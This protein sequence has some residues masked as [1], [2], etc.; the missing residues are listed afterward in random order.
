M[1]F[2]PGRPS[3]A[4]TYPGVRLVQADPEPADALP[5]HMRIPA[6]IAACRPIQD[7]LNSPAN[8]RG[9]LG[10]LGPNPGQA[11]HYKIGVDG[12]NRELADHWMDIALQGALPLSGVFGIPPAGPVRLDVLL[13]TLLVGDCTRIVQPFREPGSLALAYRVVTLQQ[14]LSAFGC[15]GSGLCHVH[16]MCRPQSHGVRLAVKHEAEN[17]RLGASRPDLEIQS[18]AIGIQSALDCFCNG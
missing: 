10:L 7:G 5:P 18:S 13:G 8:S 12:C 14:L 6:V 3:A 1:R 9:G 16:R 15:V 11:F 2:R 4:A 17:P